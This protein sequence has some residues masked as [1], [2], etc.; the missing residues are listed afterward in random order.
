MVAFNPQISYVTLTRAARITRCPERKA[1]Y[2]AQSDFWR[3]KTIAY[4]QAQIAFWKAHKPNLPGSS[5]CKECGKPCGKSAYCADCV[6]WGEFELCPVCGELT[7]APG[8]G[9]SECGFG[10]FCPDCGLDLNEGS[11]MKRVDVDCFECRVNGIRMG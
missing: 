11:H 10:G 1:L 7:F 6:R 2:T 9:C 8:E 5:R 3:E 4:R